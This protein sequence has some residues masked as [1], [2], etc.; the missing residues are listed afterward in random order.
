MNKNELNEILNK[1]IKHAE[2]IFVYEGGIPTAYK[3]A[4]Y[5]PD[6]PDTFFKYVSHIDR[7]YQ[8]LKNIS[9]NKLY[10]HKVRIDNKLVYMFVYRVKDDVYVFV[11]SDSL[12]IEL[13]HI[14]FEQVIKPIISYFR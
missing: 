11:F 7:I 6:N 1:P 3:F 9:F 10:H 14:L 12:D 4:P 5:V 2:A 13:G 8:H